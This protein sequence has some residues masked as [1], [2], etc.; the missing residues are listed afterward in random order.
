[1][2]NFI[3][4]G[5]VLD[6][7]APAPVSPG[8]VVEVG[9]LIGVAVTQADTGGVFA[10]DVNNVFELPKDGSAFTSGQS[11][12]WDGSQVVGTEAGNRFLGVVTTAAG[13]GAA[14]ARVKVGMPITTGV[15]AALIEMAQKLDADPGVSATDYEAEVVDEF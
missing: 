7:T 13:A 4:R 9:N 12:F 11:A 5:D 8:D 14:I 6:M 1:M 15:V 3:Q 2:K 10:L